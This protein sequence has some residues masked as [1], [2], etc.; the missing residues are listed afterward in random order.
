[1]PCCVRGQWR[2]QLSLACLAGSADVSDEVVDVVLPVN[3]G[4]NKYSL[5]WMRMEGLDVGSC[6]EDGC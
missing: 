5:R 2:D 1:M 4:V 6:I 3:Q